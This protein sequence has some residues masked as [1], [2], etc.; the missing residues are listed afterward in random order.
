MSGKRL[1][2]EKFEDADRRLA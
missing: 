1:R 2:T